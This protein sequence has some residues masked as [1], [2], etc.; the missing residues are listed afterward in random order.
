MLKNNYMRDATMHRTDS[1]NSIIAS[2]VNI[3]DDF[4]GSGGQES[5]IPYF[6]FRTKLFFEL[7]DAS[8]SF[9]V[10]PLQLDLISNK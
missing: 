2:Q 8:L 6:S 3:N 4:R 1:S 7:A 5:V 10:L 9:F